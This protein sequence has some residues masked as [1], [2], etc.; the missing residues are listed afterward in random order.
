ML[1]RAPSNSLLEDV[2]YSLI[3]P[4]DPAFLLIPSIR[5]LIDSYLVVVLAE[6][7]GLGKFIKVL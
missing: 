2:H 5:S 1:L 4:C 7:Q 3:F 6:S